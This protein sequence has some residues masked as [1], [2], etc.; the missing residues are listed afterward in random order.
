MYSEEPFVYNDI[1]FEQACLIFNLGGMFSQKAAFEPRVAD[2]V[3]LISLCTFYSHKEKRQIWML[4][5]YELKFWFCGKQLKFVLP[6]NSEPE[7][8]IFVFMGIRDQ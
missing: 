2:E 6:F 1:R 8:N 3:S 4:L 7:K 5:K